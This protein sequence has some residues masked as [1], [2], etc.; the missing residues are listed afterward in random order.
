MGLDAGLTL[1]DYKLET[2]LEYNEIRRNKLKELGSGKDF[3]DWESEI[4]T[5]ILWT[6]YWDVAHILSD[7]NKGDKEVELEENRELLIDK[8]ELISIINHMENHER[9]L[10]EHIFELKQ[11]LKTIDFN[12]QTLFYWENY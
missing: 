7:S 1:M 6:S 5:Q 8:E 12:K 3:Y 9:D 10:S 4:T 2:D 11:A